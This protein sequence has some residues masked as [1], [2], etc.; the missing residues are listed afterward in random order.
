MKH[1]PAGMTACLVLLLPSSCSDGARQTS[2]HADSD[3]D[4]G[5]NCEAENVFCALTCALEDVQQAANAAMASGL[6]DTTVYV[7]E[8]NPNPYTWPTD[9]N[10]SLSTDADRVIRLIGSGKDTTGIIHFQVGVP[11][12]T[13]LNLVELAHMTFDGGD[14]VD[15]IMSYR[16]RPETLNT[17][18]YWHDFV[19][20]N[21][22]ASYTLSLEGWFG[23]ISNIEMW[24]EELGSRQNPYG[25]GVLGDGVYSDHTLDFGT[26][27]AL[28]IE[29]SLFDS[30]SHTVSCFCDAYVVFRHNTVSRSDSHTDLHGPG[31]NYCYYNPDEKTAGGGYELYDNQF[32]SSQMNWVINARAGQ[33]HVITGNHFDSDSY[34]I[35]LYWDSGSS[36]YGNNCGTGPG[37]TCGRCHTLNCNG[38]CQA[39]EKTYIWGNDGSVL[40]YLG[41]A[42]DCLIEN[43]TYFLR[44]PNMDDDGFSW[45]PFT[46]PHPLRSGG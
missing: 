26:R 5:P 14:A 10:L 16:L 28:F 12:S 39:Q 42:D 25:I 19:I 7:P 41:G 1:L 44:P 17:E 32:V 2:P 6:P 21:Y 23:V 34:Q 4:G 30:C 31:Y 45:A 22:T 13:R 36:N 8:C 18:L 46:Y 3:T 24:C 11:S 27:N 33:G 43:E 35:V 9:S 20:R 40:E 29:D 38:C 37:E 15:S